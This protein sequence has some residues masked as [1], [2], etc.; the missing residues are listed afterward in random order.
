MTP[1]LIALNALRHAY[2]STT[3]LD[4]DRVVIPPGTTAILGPNGAGKTTLLRL[5]ATVAAVPPGTV[6]IDGVDVADPEHR[7]AVRRQLGYASQLDNLPPRMRVSEYCDYVAA[8]KE[9]TPRRRRRRWTDYIL[10]EVGLTNH[11]EDRIASLSG[12][13]RRRLVLA[14]SLLGHPTLL[15][16][17]EPLV[18]LDAEHRSLMVRLIA[19]SATTRT[20]VVATHHSDEMAAV[21]QHVMVLIAGRLFFAGPPDQLAER[22]VGQVWETS[23]PIN[24]SAVRALGPNRFRVVGSRPDGGVAA[25]PTVHDGYLAILNSSVHPIA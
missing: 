9:I 11:S 16:L 17:D 19:A 24:H 6:M 10:G 20:T 13:M 5:L 21:C 18:S 12:G 4:L 15:V 7:L 25:D 1:P 3:V 22:A 2:G 23:Q 14:Q 8:L